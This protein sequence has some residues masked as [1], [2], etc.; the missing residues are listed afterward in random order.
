MKSLIYWSVMTF[1][2]YWSLMTSLI[3][4]LIVPGG[5]IVLFA[6]LQVIQHLRQRN[7]GTLGICT[8]KG[9]IL[10]ENH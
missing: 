10:P 2:I 7:L 3:Y 8:H 6:Q 4:W 5:G 1:L 9:G